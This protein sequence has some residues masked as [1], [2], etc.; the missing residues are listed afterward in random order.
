MARAETWLASRLLKVETERV[1][2]RLALDEGVNLK[3]L[4][5]AGAEAAGLWSRMNLFEISAEIC[6]LA[7]TIAPG[8]RLRSLDALHLATYRIA[9]RLDPDTRLLSFDERILTAI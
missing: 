3:A 1:L 2:L 7:G 6:D 4:H 5:S 8:S 9:V